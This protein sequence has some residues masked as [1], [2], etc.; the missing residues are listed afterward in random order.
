MHNLTKT[1]THARVTL[2]LL[3]KVKGVFKSVVVVT[4]QSVFHKKKTSK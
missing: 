1:Q 4:F 3:Y 2:T